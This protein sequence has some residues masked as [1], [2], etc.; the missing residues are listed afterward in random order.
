MSETPIKITCGHY[1]WSHLADM[2]SIPFRNWNLPSIP[3][4]ELIFLEV[5]LI[6]LDTGIDF[7]GFIDLILLIVIP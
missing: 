4:L 7:V 3:I 6:F 2:G 1:H 5:E